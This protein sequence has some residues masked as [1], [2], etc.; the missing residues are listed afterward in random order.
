M[1]ALISMLSKP[2]EHVDSN[3]LIDTFFVEKREDQPGSI[4]NGGPKKGG[5]TGG[6]GGATPRPSPFAVERTTGGFIVRPAAGV[7]VPGSIDVEVAYTVR[8]GNPLKNYSP[9]D[10]RL[11]RAPITHTVSGAKISKIDGNML[12]IAPS[13]A[14]FRVELSGFDKN[15]DLYVRARIAGGEQ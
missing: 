13:G 11:D 9:L 7:D 3:A 15:R 1:G 8:R 12:T 6:G 10:F 2:V 4:S 14:D 5:A